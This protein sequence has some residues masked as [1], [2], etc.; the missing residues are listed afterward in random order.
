VRGKRKTNIE[1]P[2]SSLVECGPVSTGKRLLTA[3]E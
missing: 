2:D 1:V 3:G